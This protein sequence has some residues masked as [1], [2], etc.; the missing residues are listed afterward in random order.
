MS[1]T[2]IEIDDFKPELLVGKKIFFQPMDKSVSPVIMELGKIKK[3]IKCH[4]RGWTYVGR[5][6]LVTYSLKNRD[7]KS[8]HWIT[9][10]KVIKDLIEKG[11]H[12]GKFGLKYQI[13]EEQ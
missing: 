13:H 10:Y 8:K 11:V 2:E 1:E 9:D 6:D 12:N 7:I 5:A 4:S 3:H